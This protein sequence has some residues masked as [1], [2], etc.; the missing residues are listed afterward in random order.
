MNIEK[1]NKVIFE[2][3][4]WKL[5]F[6]F[7]CYGVKID[8]R[9][10]SLEM[11]NVLRKML[12]EVG[13]ISDFGDSQTI[14]SL[15]TSQKKSIN[16]LYFNEE[17]ALKFEKYRDV[18]LEGLIDKFL[19]I[20]S[21]SSLPKNIYLHAGAIVWNNYGIMLPGESYSGKTTLVKEFIKAGAVYITDDLTVLKG[22]G[23]LLPF[24]RTLAIRTDSGRELRTAESFGARTLTKRS[25]LKIILFTEFEEKAR[26]EPRK[27]PPGQAVMKLM[28]NF[29]YKPAVRQA[30]AQIVKT[31]ARLTGEIEIFTSKRGD[32]G[33][34]IDWVAERF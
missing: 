28:S 34:V 27:L 26:W 31:L 3:I 5:N 7:E 2:E 19:I 14:V 21:I 32:A 1:I 4:D 16:G 10:D 9:T 11:E 23:E 22:T 29:Y 33:S 8:L 15:L 24:P 20:L 18:L 17:P 6:G 25:Q 13:R 12:P 30:P